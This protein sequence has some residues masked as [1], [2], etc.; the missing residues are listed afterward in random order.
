[1]ELEIYSNK[2]WE[3]GGRVWKCK[4]VVKSVGKIVGYRKVV[5]AAE[6]PTEFTIERTC[7]AGC[8]EKLGPLISK[9]ESPYS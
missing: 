4:A 7:L 2:V 1:M 5:I 3:A 9:V 8:S 6:K